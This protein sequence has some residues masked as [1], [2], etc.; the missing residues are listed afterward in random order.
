MEESCHPHVRVEEEEADGD[1]REPASL[2]DC[3]AVIRWQAAFLL[4]NHHVPVDLGMFP[5][6]M[7]FL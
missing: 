5:G 7:P 3:T 2:A 1:I 6:A 4:G